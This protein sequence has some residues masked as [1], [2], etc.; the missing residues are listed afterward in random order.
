MQVTTK[1]AD[2]HQTDASGQQKC[3]K[4]GCYKK[5]RQ[6]ACIDDHSAP[7]RGKTETAVNSKKTVMQQEGS[8]K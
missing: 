4:A 6:E 3:I 1:T 7:F 5:A 8:T 2:R